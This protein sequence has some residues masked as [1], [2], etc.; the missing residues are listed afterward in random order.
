VTARIQR[1]LIQ[2]ALF[3]YNVLADEGLCR[4]ICGVTLVICLPCGCRMIAGCGSR[5]AEISTEIVANR[6]DFVMYQD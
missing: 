1:L 5:L 6:V 3:V 4:E 2:Q